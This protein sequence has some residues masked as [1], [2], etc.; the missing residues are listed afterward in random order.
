MNDEGQVNSM[1][2]RLRSVLKSVT[3]VAKNR[4][5]SCYK[6]SQICQIWQAVTYKSVKDATIVIHCI[7]NIKQY[8]PIVTRF[9]GLIHW[10]SSS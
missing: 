6:L 7:A 8:D 10:R 1:L 3:Y 2:V 4:N 5:V 9:P